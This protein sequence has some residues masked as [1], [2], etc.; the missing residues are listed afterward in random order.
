MTRP[1]SPTS[2]SRKTLR[3]RRRSG[4]IRRGCSKFTENSALLPLCSSYSVSVGSCSCFSL[5]YYLPPPNEFERG[6]RYLLRGAFGQFRLNFATIFK[7]F[8]IPKIDIDL[9]PRDWI[10]TFGLSCSVS[11]W[12]MRLLLQ[13]RQKVTF[14]ASKGASIGQRSFNIAYSAI[15]RIKGMQA[16]AQSAVAY[17]ETGEKLHEIADEEDVKKSTVFGAFSCLRRWLPCIFGRE[18]HHDADSRRYMGLTTKLHL[19]YRDKVTPFFPTPEQLRVEQGGHGGRKGRE[20][21]NGERRDPGPRSPGSASGC[22]PERGPPKEAL[23]RRERHAHRCTSRFERRRTCA[24]PT[25]A[26]RRTHGRSAFSCTTT[27]TTCDWAS[28]ARTGRLTTSRR[29]PSI[30]RCRRSGTTRK[31][32]GRA[33]QRTSG[34]LASR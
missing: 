31:W 12:S 5:L 11:V 30:R 20:E 33:F 13:H 32:S 16:S 24:R 7:N 27:T 4:A 22:V 29:A 10:P 2:K 25:T 28:K 34:R 8:T 26:A 6:Y 21:P 19:E 17:A 23:L 18:E 9:K 15:N 1:R 14:V 3:G